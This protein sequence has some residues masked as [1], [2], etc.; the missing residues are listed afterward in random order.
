MTQQVDKPII[1]V[2]AG[3][4]VKDGHYFLAQR[5]PN[6]SQGGL[7]EFPGG[8][9]E[10]GET[11]EQALER[12]LHEELTINTVTGQWLADSVFDYGDKVI[13]LKGYLSHWQAGDV[14][15]HSHQAMAWVLL[16]DL[17]RYD[18]CPADLPIV[19]ALQAL[20]M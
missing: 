8:K 13:E 4:I 20:A 9:V 7:W 15:L 11:P 2:V 19:D 17:S 10:A 1:T 18:L 3:V 6:A 14:E 5:L 12:E 16:E